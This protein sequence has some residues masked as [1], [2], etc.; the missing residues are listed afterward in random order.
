MRHFVFILGFFDSII[1]TKF[2]R[3]LNQNRSDSA[4]ATDNQNA[5]TLPSPS[6][7]ASESKSN[8]HAVMEVNGIPAASVKPSDFGLLPTIRSSTA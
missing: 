2:L 8:S 5:L 1:W 4:S 3:K 6:S 7:A